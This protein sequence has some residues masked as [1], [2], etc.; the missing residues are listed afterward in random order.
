MVL[1][2]VLSLLFFAYY[3]LFLLQLYNEFSFIDM[4]GE[5][6]ILF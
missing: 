1:S 6:F 4:V 2:L 5:I 3:S